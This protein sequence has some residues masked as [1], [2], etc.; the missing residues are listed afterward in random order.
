MKVVSET[1]HYPWTLVCTCLHFYLQ[2]ST[3]QFSMMV[4]DMFLLSKR[5]TFFCFLLL[6]LPCQCHDKY[7]PVCGLNGKTYRSLCFA[8]CA[9]L[10]TKQLS[11]GQCSSVNPCHSFPCSDNKLCVVDRKVCVGSMSSCPQF[12]CS[13]CQL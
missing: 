7:Q 8:S 11:N 1:L 2:I 13:R 5:Q 12:L 9:G 3:L 4:K 10:K 6:G